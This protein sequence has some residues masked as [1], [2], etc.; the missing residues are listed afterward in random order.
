[1]CVGY[2]TDQDES[3]DEGANHYS[4]FH[5]IDWL[6]DIAKDRLRHRSIIKKRKGTIPNKLS[7]AC[8]A[9]SGWLIV[10][11]IAVSVGGVA[12]KSHT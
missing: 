6:K 7:S 4:D 5:T 10:F 1:M 2:A 9:A 11:L 3:L 12:G 8:D